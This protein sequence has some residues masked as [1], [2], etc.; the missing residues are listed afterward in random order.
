MKATSTSFLLLAL[1][2]VCTDA[3]SQSS[4][5]GT[6][7]IDTGK[8]ENLASEKPRVLS[9][10]DGV[11]RE[12]DRQL[13]AD[14][15]DQKVPA[16]GYWDTVSVRIVDDRTVEIVS[17]KAGK[18][19]YTETDTVSVDGNTLTKVMKDSTEA[20]A[21]TFESDF[22]RIAPTPAGAHAVSGSWQVFKQSRS[23]NSTII[24][25]KCTAQGFTAETPLGEKLEAKFDG[26]LYEMQDDPGHTMVSVKLINPYTVEQT[27]VREGKIVFVVTLEVTP[28]GK[29]IHATLKSKEDGGVKTWTLHKQSK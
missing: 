4:F 18:V 6:W 19:T 25:Y 23:E 3:R 1:C 13:K 27:N 5:D 22:R 10:S 28:D 12:G 24:K 9:V 2:V 26:K 20:E 11:F 7:V 29:T 21:V 17:K 14:G 16:N 15:S 8:N